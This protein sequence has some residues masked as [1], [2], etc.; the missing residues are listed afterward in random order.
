MQLLT[1]RVIMI[2]PDRFGF[3]PQTA[4]SNDWQNI[5]PD[6]K[7]TRENALKEFKTMVQ[8]LRKEGIEVSILTSRK[9]AV[10]PDAVFPNNWFSIHTDEGKNKIVI[11][12]MLAPNRRE[13]RQVKNLLEKL[14]GIGISNIEIIDL[15]PDEKNGLILEGTGSMVL[16]R[17][18]KIAY[19]LASPRTIEEEFNKWLKLMAY[20]G[21]FFHAVANTGNPIY[22]TNVAMSVGD[23]FAV[24]CTEAIPV[25]ERSKVVNS[26]KTHS[27][28]IEISLDQVSHFAG[29]ILHLRAADGTPKIILSKNAYHAFTSA[30][31][32]ILQKYGQLVP[33][34]ISTIETVGGGSA[35][36]MLAEVFPA[37]SS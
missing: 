25:K 21:V 17:K 36:C 24:L 15:S 23:G 26:L 5:P 29:N 2:S 8:T 37:K 4:G 34:D 33:V 16:D 35:R 32:Q 28:I 9:D 14:E 11:Y 30:Q 19:T 7:K 18:H 22:H 13:E 6:E 20:K 12:P 1:N 31:K 3:N 27:E 10:T